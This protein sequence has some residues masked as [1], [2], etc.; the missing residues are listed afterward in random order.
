MN[1]TILL[2]ICLARVQ[3]TFSYLIIN[4]SLTHIPVV[5]TKYSTQISFKLSTSWSWNYLK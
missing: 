4:L 2:H 1:F 3:H 5:F